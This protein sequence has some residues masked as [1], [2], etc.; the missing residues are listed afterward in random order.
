MKLPA[1]SLPVG[2]GTELACVR[3]VFGCH[4]PRTLS[5][6]SQISRAFSDSGVLVSGDWGKTASSFC[7]ST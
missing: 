2:L 5:S 7:P 4:V 3:V 6:I 1:E